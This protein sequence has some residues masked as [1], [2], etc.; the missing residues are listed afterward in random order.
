MNT[1]TTSNTQAPLRV[2]DY[3]Q[4]DA[5]L[6]VTLGSFT[7]RQFHRRDSI[8]SVPSTRLLAPRAECMSSNVGERFEDYERGGA[9][10]AAVGMGPDLRLGER[11][12]MRR[13]GEW[14][15]CPASSPSPNDL[16]GE[17]GPR[18]GENVSSG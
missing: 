4:R 6:A 10:S 16:V 15:L 3:C 13:R 11:G 1:R 14:G 18:D 7:V 5:G 17:P 8:A 12:Q 9:W 2:R